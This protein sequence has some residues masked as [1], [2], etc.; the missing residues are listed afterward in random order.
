[1]IKKILYLLLIT[2]IPISSNP[3]NLAQE[4]TK[5]TKIKNTFDLISSY[6]QIAKQIDKNDSTRLSKKFI[7]KIKTLHKLCHDNKSIKI[8]LA[9]KNLLQTSI[10]NQKLKSIDHT[11]ILSGLIS[12][13]EPFEIDQAKETLTQAESKLTTESH[14]VTEPSPQTTFDA[15][16]QKILREKIST[17]NRNDI[18][19]LLLLKK[20]ANQIEQLKSELTDV[21]ED[22]THISKQDATIKQTFRK[23][24]KIEKLI[25]QNNFEGQIFVRSPTTNIELSEELAEELDDCSTLLQEII[26]KEL[27]D[28]SSPFFDTNNRAK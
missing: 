25:Q 27:S 12:Y 4:L 11:N 20:L 8:K 19:S 10:A 23:L 15:T 24:L 3:F 18:I 1:M 2:I 7:R 6:Q 14:A 28:P 21:K 16:K 17:I 22:V 9:F 5:T 13:Y 26:T